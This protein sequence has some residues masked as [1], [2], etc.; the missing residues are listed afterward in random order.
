MK[1]GDVVAKPDRGCLNCA[2]ILARQEMYSRIIQAVSEFYGITREQIMSCDRS[3]PVVTARQVA[4]Y[5][6]RTHKRDPLSA[7]AYV[8]GKTFAT[9]LH[10]VQMIKRRIEIEP[11][12]RNAVKEIIFSIQRL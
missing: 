4:M 12:L 2:N 11:D 3:L 8:F 5:V 1:L 10:H 6:A 7:I 9:V